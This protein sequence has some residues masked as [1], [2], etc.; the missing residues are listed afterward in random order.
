MKNY[1]RDKIISTFNDYSIAFYFVPII[2]SLSVLVITEGEIS[3]FLSGMVYTGISAKLIGSIF[4]VLSI[5]LFYGIFIEI[6]IKIGGGNLFRKCIIYLVKSLFLYTYI[7]VI[8]YPIIWQSKM[9]YLLLFLICF[10]FQKI[11]MIKIRQ[12]LK[13]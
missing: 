12:I 5:V 9:V 6:P 2:S 11:L 3:H 13:I 10:I 1:E 4:L 8:I 7:L